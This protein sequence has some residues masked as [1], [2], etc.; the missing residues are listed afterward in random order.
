MSATDRILDKLE[1]IDDRLREVEQ[2][3]ERI[4]TEQRNASARISR[5]TEAAESLEG[6]VRALETGNAERKGASKLATALIAVGGSGGVV[7]LS[8]LLEMISGGG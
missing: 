4:E 2:T 7:G 3:C 5:E 8:K 6:R 1:D